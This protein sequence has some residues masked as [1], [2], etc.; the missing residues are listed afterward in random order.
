MPTGIRPNDEPA[1]LADWAARTIQW[2]PARTAAKYGAH[3]LASV[4]G[5]AKRRSGDLPWGNIFAASPPKAG[6][7]WIKAVFDHPVMRAHTGL[8]TLPQLDYR[9]RTRRLPYGT[10]VPGV[11]T[12]YD[13]YRALDKPWPHRTVYIFRDPRDLVVSGYFS[14]VQT[15]REMP[16]YEHLRDE[17]RALP[18]DEGLLRSIE[19][20]RPR[21]AEMASWVGVQD[22]SVLA[23]R[24]EEVGADH[25]GHVRRIVDHCGFRMGPGELEALV[26]ETSRDSLQAKDL[27]S[28]EPGS[29]SH[30]RRDRRGFRELFDERHREALEQAA[31]GLATALGYPD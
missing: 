8:M 2:W 16:G 26:S 30:Y 18:L 29:E 11:Y 7:Q 9:G 13:D 28:R 19:I 14:A 31:P 25:A 1:R 22:E 20:M 12:S 15:H 3:G 21:L 5:T 10:F 23:L 6:S 4:R 17:L 27:A 24:L